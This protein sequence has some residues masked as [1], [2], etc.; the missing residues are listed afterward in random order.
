MKKLVPIVIALIISCPKPGL[1]KIAAQDYL[2]E[3]LRV[4]KHAPLYAFSLLADSLIGT[5]HAQKKAEIQI[6]IY[7]EQR[8]YRR[9]AALLDTF[10]WNINLTSGEIE[11]ILLKTE[12][13]NTLIDHTTDSLLQGIAYFHLEDYYQAITFLSAPLP[14][15]DYRMLTLAKAY[16]A[17]E[18][19]RST[20]AV[21]MAIN[22]ISPYLYQEY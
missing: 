14:P 3:A 22:D 10:G 20:Y 11:T 16:N 18:D 2:Q 12:R 13:W 1:Q 9:A 19:Y 15:H 4:Y 21:L 17:L 8:E 5:K 7:L 6:K